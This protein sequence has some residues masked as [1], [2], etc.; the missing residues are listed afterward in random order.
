[1]EETMIAEIEQLSEKVELARETIIRL[2]ADNRSL[3][4]ECDDLRRRMEVFEAMG[5]TPEE[6]ERVTRQAQALAQ[7]RDD[8]LREREE[9]VGR[10][11]GL[12]TKVEALEELS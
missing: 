4:L 5:A 1:L 9:I 11:R 10:V 8:L 2:R 12:L 6:V 3:R 7:E